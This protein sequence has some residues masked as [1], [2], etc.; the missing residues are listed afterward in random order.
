MLFLIFAYSERPVEE[1]PL[2]IPKTPSFNEQLLDLSPNRWV[3]IRV[4][5]GGEWRRQRHAAA[6]FDTH[7]NKLFV[8][9][10]DTHGENWDNSIHE[11]DPVILQWFEHYPPA[12]RG[13]YRAD[14]EGHPVAGLEAMQPW[15]MHVYDNLVYDPSLDALLVM[16]RAEHNP[17]IRTVRGVKRHPTW[18]YDLGTRRWRALDNPDGEPPFTYGGAS[19]YDAGRDVVVTYG[20]KGVWE[21]GPDRSR[22]RLATTE[23]HHEKQHSMAYDGRHHKLAVFGG[24]KGSNRV[25]IYTPGAMAGER[26]HWEE[27][28]P[29]G[30]PCPV[31]TAIPV[32]YDSDNGVFLLV[33]DNPPGEGEDRPSSSSTFVYDLDTN[34]YIRLPHADMPALGMN[35]MMTYDPSNKVFLLI[36]GDWRRPPAVW[37]LH[38]E[39]FPFEKRLAPDT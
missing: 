34:R 37:A 29:S 26:G 31:D 14:A 17:A 4:P 16:A 1:E 8:F 27:R 36:T 22:W 18:I 39:L 24:R 35:Y 23:T 9:G 11:F 13:T 25:W 12:R 2:L 15:A 28:T 6:A 32:A 10:S 19:A 7:R 3:R 38:L 20:S 21:L 33:P 30:D 5:F